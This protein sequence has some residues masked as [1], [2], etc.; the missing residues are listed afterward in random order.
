MTTPQ[1]YRWRAGADRPGE[2]EDGST[3]VTPKR[4]IALLDC[5]VKFNIL[6]SLAYLQCETTVY[7]CTATSEELLAG[8]PDGIVLSPGPGDPAQLGYVVDTVRELIGRRPIMEFAWEIRFLA[9]SSA[10]EPIN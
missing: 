9:A 10:A 6:R 3:G 2:G 1:P 4:R 7:P 5:G 8:D